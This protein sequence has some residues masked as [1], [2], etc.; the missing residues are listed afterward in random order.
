MS[1]YWRGI[2]NTAVV[3]VLL[4]GAETSLLHLLTALLA[5]SPDAAPLGWLWLWIMGLV[6]FFLPRSL[7]GASPNV[8]VL[9]V[10]LAVVLTCVLVTHASTYSNVLLLDPSWA[11]AAWSAL[12]YDRDTPLRGFP[13]AIAAAL[14]L[15]WRQVGR[16]TPGTDA[17]GTLFRWG[18]LMVAILAVAGV[19]QWQTTDTGVSL[20][21]I[22][23]A[24]FFVLTLLALGFTQ[25]I[26]TPVRAGSGQLGSVAG[27]LTTSALPLL[28]AAIVAVV[29]S[30]L[31]FGTIAPVARFLAET[32][33]TIVF[34][35]FV[36][37]G[38]VLTAIAW[39][40]AW[41]I[42]AILSFL[43]D[44]PFRRPQPPNP[45]Q[46]ANAWRDALRQRVLE[47]PD[48]IVWSVALG[49]LLLVLYVLTRYRPRRESL[50]GVPIARESVWEPPDL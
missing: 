31:L 12:V 42:A 49:A 16:E 25:W 32:A 10:A 6:A 35:A 41:L 17:A 13:L 3:V 22:R 14:G 43:P 2:G 26:E 11:S 19:T 8:Y 15:W 27:W 48:W 39:P 36:A 24:M 30:A 33:A 28:F 47:M 50:A 1:K 9:T 46:N 37:I 20:L 38:A 44:I 23:I 29:L 18:P 7:S 5:G 21:T 40:L 45:E 4:T 34:L